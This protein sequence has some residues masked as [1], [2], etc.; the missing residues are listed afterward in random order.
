MF[1]LFQQKKTVL[2]IAPTGGGKTL[3]SFL[4]V[5]ADIHS[6]KPKGLHTLYI[7]P[8]KALANDIQRNLK[9]PLIEMGLN[10]SI[11]I[12]SGD[13]S[14]YRR[15][16]QQKKPPSILLTTPESLMLLLSYP[17]A[18]QYF[19]AL[20]TIIID[21]LHSFA[22][23]KRGDL[24]S[25]ALA[26]LNTFSPQAIRMGLSATVAEPKQLAAWLGKKGEEA[27]ILI[28][29]T[30]TPP[31]LSLLGHL[32]S[33]PYS[34]FMA[35]YAIE[36]IYEVIKKHQ[37]ILIF[38]N[39]RAQAEFIFQQLW[40]NNN[41]HLPIAIYHGSLSTEQRLK[42]E[43]LSLA[44]K[45]RAI[46]ATSA[47]ELGIDWGNIDCVLQ[48]GAPRGL[49]RLL[50]R[51]GRS[52]HQFDRASVAKLVP[53]NCFDTLECQAAIDAIQQGKLDSEPLHEGAFDV[54]VQF[55][56]NSACSHAI[57]AL[58]LFEIIKS[59]YPYRNLAKATFLQLF[60]FASNGGYVLKHYEQYHRLIEKNKKFIIASEKTA[61]RHRQN[62]GTIIESA[63][64]SVKVLNQR[65]DKILGQIEENFVQQLS[66][67]DTFMFA[68]LVLEF[69]RI[70]ALCVEAR[71]VK[72]KKIVP[73]LPA[74]LG[75]TMP[76]TSYLAAEVSALINTPSRWKLLPEKVQDWLGLQEKF[77]KLPGGDYLLVEQ[78]V[79]KKNFYITL[80][81]FEG[82]RANHSLGMLMTK[83]MEAIEL[84]PLSFTAND[85]GLAIKTLKEV[86]FE[87]IDAL[88]SPA[89]IEEDLESW[90]RFS[91][92][93]KRSFRQVA[94]ISGLIQRQQ[95]STH[96]TMRQVTFST[97]LIYDVLQRYEPQHVLLQM[98]RV[99]ANRF[100]LD[101][102]RLQQL[103]RRFEHKI[104]FVALTKPS[105]MSIS[106]LTT[107]KTENIQGDA[108]QEL[109]LQQENEC[110][111]EKLI[112]EV[113]CRVKK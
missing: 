44:Q 100:L 50:Q 67:G 85:Y 73:K 18:N 61:R 13:T 87:Q 113:R 21:E 43:A 89:L 106:F 6:K 22:S 77:S 23:T 55:I 71:K 81:C 10:V 26:Q 88:F 46:V 45:L 93:L 17:D 103:L 12:R 90:L 80:Y 35:S 86:S 64:L 49:S 20:K 9:E 34:G 37:L 96:K 29:K 40:Q 111:A 28:A 108:L 97:D 47:L 5:I 82:R 75:G 51:I 2:L 38:V 72:S 99:D 102:E 30:K 36:E 95:A 65:K 63:Y 68:G 16:Q 101:L 7:S 14:S 11:E 42:I 31:K 94:I 69:I 1:R 112:N 24:L 92:L 48:V 98:T 33:V 8:L 53:A 107:F 83:R 57:E 105:P 27:E 91:S 104:K 32:A 39:T 59:A 62:I 19:A 25:L 58:G 70:H 66:Q 41:D 52:N 60:E 79:Y 3:A 15:R 74:Y 84:M 54:V 76:L 109:L 110:L 56:I 78:Y 4:P